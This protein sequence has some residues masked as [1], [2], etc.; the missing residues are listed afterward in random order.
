LLPLP[1]ELPDLLEELDFVRDRLAELL[2]LPL[3]VLPLPVARFEVEPL[4]L[5]E[6]ELLPRF[7][8]G[9]LP[10][11]EAELLPRFEAELLPRLEAELLPDFVA[12]L[13]PPWRLD[14][15]DSL[16]DSCEE[17]L[18]PVPSSCSSSSF[19]MSFFAT[20]TAAGTATPRAAPAMT[21]LPVDIPSLSSCSFSFSLSFSF[22]IWSSS[23]SLERQLSTGLVERLDEA[24][25]DPFADD[26]RSVL[27]EIT[28][29]GSC[30]VLGR[31]EE[32][33]SRG[34]PP[35]REHGVQD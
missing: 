27:G 26:L 8:A 11:F 5:F 13:V 35:A 22:S 25:D 3:L 18:W 32:G 4:P 33:V 30:C 6:L 20:P 24:W 15:P 7:E 19:P 16:S 1:D 34:V 31:R 9:L 28:A 21:F 17:S 10:R 23:A 2:R 29:D 14:R 12:V